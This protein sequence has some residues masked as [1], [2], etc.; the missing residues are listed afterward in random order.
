MR[1]RERVEK[2][3][4][5]TAGEARSLMMGEMDGCFFLGNF[6]KSVFINMEI[7]ESTHAC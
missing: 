3:K 4:L 2:E 1:G 5:P 6:V 7:D